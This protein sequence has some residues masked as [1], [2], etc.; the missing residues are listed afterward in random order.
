MIHVESKK[1]GTLK[2]TTSKPNAF[3]GLR[4]RLAAFISKHMV[5]QVFPGILFWLVRYLWQVPTPV[6]GLRASV[7]T[8]L[9]TDS[10]DLWVWT[11]WD[12]GMMGSNLAQDVC[13]SAFWVRCP[14]LEHRSWK[15]AISHSTMSSTLK[16]RE[17]FK[18]QVVPVPDN[19]LSIVH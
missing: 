9:W 16:R 11:T 4:R 6:Y 8:G 15:W 12:T 13:V 19:V 17:M 1:K 2:C 7:L 5:Q 10:S 18:R 14:V 3:N